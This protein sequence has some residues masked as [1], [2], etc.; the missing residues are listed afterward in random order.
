MITFLVC[1][2]ILVVGYFTYGTIVDK[3]IAPNDANETPALR[4]ADGIDYMEL[5]W[6]KVLLTQ[7]LNIAGL[8]P[9]FGAIS[10]ALF[11]PVAFIWITFG[12]LFVGSVHDILAGYV[13]MKHDGLSITELVGIYLG[14]YSKYFMIVFTF[15]LLLLVGVVFTM[16]PASWLNSRIAIGQ[17]AWVL[18]ILAY[19]IIATIVPIGTVVAKIFPVLSIVMILMCVVLFAGLLFHGEFQMMEFTMAVVHPDGLAATPFIFTTIAC[20]AVSGFHATKSPMMARCI[21]KESETKRVFFGAMVIEGIVALVWA[22]VAMAVLGDRFF[23]GS[24]NAVAALG[25]AGGAVDY[26]TFTLLPNW[27]AYILVFIALIIFP[28]TSADTSFRS[29]RLMLADAFKWDQ[30]PMMKRILLCIPMFAMAYALTW[31]DFD[32]IWRYFAWSN[33]TIATITLWTGAVYLAR[34]H[35]FHWIATLPA[36]LLSSIF[37]GYILQAPEGFRLD[38]TFSNIV[39]AVFAA[40]VF[41]LFMVLLPKMKLEKS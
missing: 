28:V 15:I 10:G 40:A 24:E 7:F 3:I 30:G 9:I 26:L 16:A 22:A 21:Q 31:V 20:G 34:N 33:L 36:T 1:T 6:W 32:I 41:V 14:K 23:I 29:I 39:G 11:G 18:I 25:G 27:L 2:A 37:L 17:W 13:S 38:E 8:G 4:M 5:P 35:K 12:C 19:Y